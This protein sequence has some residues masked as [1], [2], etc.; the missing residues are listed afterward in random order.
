MRPII[1][2]IPSYQRDHERYQLEVSYIEA[3]EA[4]GGTVI[5][6][7]YC[8]SE[9]GYQHILSICDGL[10]L[11][12]G[13]DID[14]ALFGEEPY[15]GLGEVCPWRDRAELGL[16]RAALAHM[17]PILAICRGVQVLNVAAGGS[18]IQDIDREVPGCLQHRQCAPGYHASHAVECTPNS[19]LVQITG[20]SLLRVNSFHHQAVKGVAT[21][22]RAT[23]RSG[24]N[25]IEALEGPGF[26]LGIQ[27][28]PERM[29]KVD[30]AALALFESLVRAAGVKRVD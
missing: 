28:H 20:T 25:V 6:W 10:L 5:I 26:S 29:W 14:P 21:S 13:G 23:A 18:L 30:G 4:A 17:T 8:E 24:D 1:G 3:V 16:T 22:F 19:L 15:P 27:W 11:A 7:P 12:G 9:S 2:I